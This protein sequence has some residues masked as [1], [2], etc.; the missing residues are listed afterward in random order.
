MQEPGISAVQVIFDVLRTRDT[1]DYTS[2][3]LRCLDTGLY[4]EPPLKYLG[5]RVNTEESFEKIRRARIP[6]SAESLRQKVLTEIRSRIDKAARA[7]E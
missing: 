1:S 5:A 2:L 3:A 4:V 7:P 6:E